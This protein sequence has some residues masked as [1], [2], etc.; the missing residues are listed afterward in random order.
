MRMHLVAAEELLQWSQERISGQDQIKLADELS[1]AFAKHRFYEEASTLAEKALELREDVEGD[2]HPDTL[3][4]R[5]NL[6][7]TY[8]NFGNSQ[9]PK[10]SQDFEEAFDLL[11]DNIELCGRKSNGSKSAMALESQRWIVSTLIKLN[12]FD[13]AVAA[14]WQILGFWDIH[15]RQKEQAGQLD[16][17]TI[18]RSILAKHNLARSLQRVGKLE[19]LKIAQAMHL[20]NIEAWKTI[21]IEDTAGAEATASE[22]E[23]TRKALDKLLQAQTEQ[24]A[25]SV[26]AEHKRIDAKV[27]LPQWKVSRENESGIGLG[28]GKDG[29]EAVAQDA[30]KMQNA[31]PNAREPSDADIKP[32]Q[33][34][35]GARTSNHRRCGE[36]QRNTQMGSRYPELYSKGTL[37]TITPASSESYCGKSREWLH[38][39]SS[40]QRK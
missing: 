28:D 20:D 23:K 2:E 16:D 25:Q 36:V 37:R 10:D 21:N 18:G 6:A 11:S 15:I 29:K 9:V 34:R 1:H 38:D 33:K 7:I 8:Y 17:E 12:R 31:K 3:Q 32:F 19:D 26:Q 30:A 39:R 27:E 35:S 13:E 40:D 22:L 4:A 24:D 5:L 14:S